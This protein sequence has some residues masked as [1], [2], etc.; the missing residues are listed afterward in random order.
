MLEAALG[1]G[2]DSCPVMVAAAYPEPVHHEPFARVDGTVSVVGLVESPHGPPVAGG[3]PYFAG[4]SAAAAALEM[5][6]AGIR[7]T[8]FAVSPW[9]DC[10]ANASAVAAPVAAVGHP[11]DTSRVEVGTRSAASTRQ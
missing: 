3:R 9:P 11:L 1:A 4:F 6:G 7:S 2:I 10:K 8:R 5:E